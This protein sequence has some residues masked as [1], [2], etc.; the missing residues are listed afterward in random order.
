L[1]LR[2]PLRTGPLHRPQPAP[3][4]REQGLL[5][6]QTPGAPGVRLQKLLAA[7]G[8]GSR[9]EIERWIA[10]GRVAVAGRVA[11]LGERARPGDPIALD[12]RALEFRPQKGMP[13]VLAYHKPEGE[14]VTRRDPE[15]RRTV[16]ERL[17]RLPA[18]RWIAV[19]RL[20]LNSSGLLLLTD[21][22][23][24]ANRLLHPRYGLE[25][26]YAAR[27]LGELSA[28][29]KRRLCSGVR[30]ADGSARFARLQ[31]MGRGRDKSANR[32]YRVTLV[33]GRNR[34]VRRIFETVGASVSRLIR[35]RFGPVELPR[36]LKPG[37]WVELDRPL[38]ERLCAEQASAPLSRDAEFC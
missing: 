7:A 15:G 33:E 21:A 2:K 3:V 37:R 18:G 10:A 6:A 26:E 17:P 23:E 36:G 16:F 38:V 11:R 8:L 27:V 1:R 9:R 24:L 14:L 25:R 4:S 32:W 29:A 30:L 5:C 13:R 34:E 12:G 22:G 28:E 31:E 20:D 35:L 19:G